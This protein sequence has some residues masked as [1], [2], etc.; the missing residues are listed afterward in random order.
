MPPR[1][2]KPAPVTVKNFNWDSTKFEPGAGER[3]E[4]P[5][6]VEDQLAVVA[7]LEQ[8]PTRKPRTLTP[9]GKPHGKVRQKALAS[10][11]GR[12]AKP[13]QYTN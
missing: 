12:S 9:K 7:K 6:H 3:G 2:K 13:S 1:I 8:Q 5:A 11:L 4:K 10:M